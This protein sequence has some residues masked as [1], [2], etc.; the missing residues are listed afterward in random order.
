M[1]LPAL[2]TSAGFN[3]V[4]CVGFFSL[5]S[6]LRKQPVNIKV[7]FGQR[8][9]QLKAR[10]QKNLFSFDRYVPSAGWLVKAWEASDDDLYACGG[11]DGLVFLKMIVFCI[12]IFSVAA[13]LCIFLVLPVNLFGQGIQQINAESQMDIF[14]IRNVQEGSKGLWAHFFALYVIS[15]CSYVLLYIEFKSV[16]RMRLEQVI[17]FPTRPSHFTVLVRGIPWIPGLSYSE[18]VSK[19]FGSY[20]V[21]SYLA[22]Q[23]VYR[24]GT[25]QRL[26]MDAEKM[27]KV[28]KDTPINQYLAP[29][30]VGCG[31]CAGHSNSFKMLTCESDSDVKKPNQQ[32]E[33]DLKEQ[34]CAAAFVFFRTRYAAMVASRTIQV[35]DPMLWVIEFA[36]EPHDVYWENLCVPYRLL[37]IRKTLVFIGSIIFSLWF[38]LPTTLVQGLVNIAQLESTFPFLRGISQKSYA[39]IVQGYL[40]SLVLTCFALIVPPVMLMFATLEGAIS[41]SSRKKSACNKSIIFFFWNVF[42]Y[43]LFTG[44]WWDRITRFT[45]TGLK[46]MATLLGNLIP[47]QASFFMTYVMTTG[48]ASLAWELMQPYVL[49]VNWIFQFVLMRKEGFGDLYTFPY[50]TEV[51]RTLLFALLGFTF[52][53]L[54]PLILPFLLVYYFFAY[55]VYRNQILNVY[56]TRYNTNG[57]YW[58]VAHNAMI[59]SL[60]VM[61]GVAAIIFGMKDFG[62]ASTFTFV[63]IIFTSLFNVF[64]RHKF[65]PLFKNN[66]AQDLIEMDRHDE[67]SGKI[68]EI[69]PRLLASY[70]QFGPYSGN[71]PS[72]LLSADYKKCGENPVV[73]TKPKEHETSRDPATT[74]ISGSKL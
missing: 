5:Y 58:P 37:W 54:A 41:R 15:I 17:R 24:S 48:W 60:I 53:T 38:L 62:T 1:I 57:L 69:L 8:L 22:H 29:T 36:P 64:C 59:F 4:I 12:R 68:E 16:A 35:L 61:Q 9:A 47:G 7:Y 23:M 66:A 50:H 44:T 26:M 11:I 63:L 49:I 33:P 31:Q 20:Y 13:V 18:A 70:Y 32:N 42:F 52:S 27:Y 71:H 6:I 46:D 14:T 51:P 73:V 67:H 72:D 65:L 25:I 21:S 56:I 43:N 40:P 2:L 28:L 19:H 45:V 34:E 74:T 30:T 55:F 3:I 10:G 39:N